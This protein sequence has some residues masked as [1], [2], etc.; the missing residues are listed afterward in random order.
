MWQGE[1]RMP[2]LADLS[3]LGVQQIDRVV[4]IVEE[5]FK[6]HS[7]PSTAAPSP[8]VFVFSLENAVCEDP[9][10]RQHRQHRI[11]ICK[12]PYRQRFPKRK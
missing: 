3:I 4:E 5:T 11:I 7:V 12:N 1:Q 9:Y 10:R 2:E 6:G 8:R